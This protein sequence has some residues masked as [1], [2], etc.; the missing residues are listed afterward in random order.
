MRGKSL[1]PT[2]KE[3]LK[4]QFVT[5]LKSSS[6]YLN[7]SKGVLIAILQQSIKAA[8][9]VPEEED[10]HNEHEDTV[11]QGDQGEP[12]DD[13][14]CDVP[15]AKLSDPQTLKKMATKQ[16][17]V[18]SDENQKVLEDFQKLTTKFARD[19][20][21]LFHRVSDKKNVIGLNALLSAAMSLKQTTSITSDQQVSTGHHVVNK[22]STNSKSSADSSDTSSSEVSCSLSERNIS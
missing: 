12:E 5:S 2:A 22:V 11:D 10:D 1:S 3:R 8:G 21:N 7:A 9:E 6:A 20:R 4:Q 16:T 13:D 17:K 19:V 18:I 14:I 15:V